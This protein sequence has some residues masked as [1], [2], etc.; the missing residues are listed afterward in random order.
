MGI[1]TAFAVI[2]LATA[3]V[4]GMFP[5]CDATVASICKYIPAIT[6][7][8]TICG[9]W[10]VAAS[11]QS[12]LLQ[13]EVFRRTRARPRAVMVPWLNPLER[14]FCL[15]GTAWALKTTPQVRIWI[16]E[17]RYV[18]TPLYRPRCRAAA[19]PQLQAFQVYDVHL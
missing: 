11:R 6:T 12:V 16:C 19:R 4:Y 9:T 7:S 18:L 14:K 2:M 13:D 17:G 5:G 8:K 10:L 1:V 15:P 3:G